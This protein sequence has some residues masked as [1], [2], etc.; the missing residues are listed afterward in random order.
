MVTHVLYTLLWV[1]PAVAGYPPE[2]GACAV[3]NATAAKRGVKT[4]KKARKIVYPTCTY[5]QAQLRDVRAALGSL[6]Q[7]TGYDIPHRCADVWS[8][9]RAGGADAQPGN[10]T[11]ATEPPRE[12]AFARYLAR[13]QKRQQKRR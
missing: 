7:E 4:T 9:A 2:L 6:L 10:V 1:M 8:G 12:D 11:D 5:T 13:Q 3:T